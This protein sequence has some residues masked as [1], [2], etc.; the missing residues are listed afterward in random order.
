MRNEIANAPTQNGADRDE[1]GRFLPGNP[2]GPGNPH[3]AQLAAWRATFT[4]AVT[5]EDLRE[6]IVQLVEAG[7][8]GEP[9]AVKELLDRCLGKPQPAEQLPAGVE[10]EGITIVFKPA[11]RPP[12]PD[13]ERERD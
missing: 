1:R 3:A 10:A 9:W 5:S 4:A 13:D 6:V 12:P 7:K 2:G 8:K 11:E